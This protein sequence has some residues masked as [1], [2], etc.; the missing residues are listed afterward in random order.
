MRDV[1]TEEVIDGWWKYRDDYE[2]TL[3]E[4]MPARSNGAF[5]AIGL[6]HVGVRDRNGFFE[7]GAWHTM[8][9]GAAP[10]GAEAWERIPGVKTFEEAKGVALAM[11]GMGI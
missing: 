9:H 8:T 10:T 7:A 5:L 6:C 3:Y 2:W 1:T 11:W 4:Y